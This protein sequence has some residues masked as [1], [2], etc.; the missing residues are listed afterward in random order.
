MTA[1]VVLLSKLF[2]HDFTHTRTRMQ[3]PATKSAE[4]KSHSRTPLLVISLALPLPFH[5]SRFFLLPHPSTYF[6]GLAE[7]RFSLQKF[8]PNAMVAYL[9][10]LLFPFIQLIRF[11]KFMRSLLI[12]YPHLIH[13]FTI[14]LHAFSCFCYTHRVYYTLCASISGSYFEKLLD[15]RCLP[16]AAWCLASASLLL[17]IVFIFR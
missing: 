3:P 17:H 16:L 6:H 2:A 11:L 13:Q 4:K 8:P 5:R 10:S 1:C 12:I 15:A 14:L 7:Q 9:A